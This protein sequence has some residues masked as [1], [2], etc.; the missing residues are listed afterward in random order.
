MLKKIIEIL[1]VLFSFWEQLKRGS[2]K[3]GK[4]NSLR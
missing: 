3:N 2:G 1:K 4:N